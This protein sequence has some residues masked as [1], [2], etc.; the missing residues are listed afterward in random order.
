MIRY[1][2]VV[3][4]VVACYSPS[5]NNCEITCAAGAC[6]SGYTCEG[7]LCRIEGGAACTDAG[8]PPG[9]DADADGI[10]NS[11]DNCPMLPNADQAN[12][13]RD[14]RGDLCDPCPIKGDAAADM[15]SDSDGV[16]DGCDP[17]PGEMS[18]IAI[19]EGFNAAPMTTPRLLPSASSWVF[20]SGKASVSN[21]GPNAFASMTWPMPM[22]STGEL[23]AAAF[24][25]NQP[26]TTPP[27]G[28]GVTAYYDTSTAGVGIV[29]MVGRES[30]GDGLALYKRGVSGSQVTSMYALQSGAPVAAAMARAGDA[31]QCRDHENRTVMNTYAAP[32]TTAPHAGLHVVAAG[33]TFEYV[34]IVSRK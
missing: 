33:V 22:G 29:C 25:I 24:A 16:G 1:L 26:S 31:Y 17:F 21:P 13:D 28:A 19:F 8:L 10:I 3:T 11:M 15:D 30:F 18:R 27:T 12:E 5:Y 2:L 20:Q 23:V 6:P 9:G 34:M 14:A 4:C 32:A 7:G